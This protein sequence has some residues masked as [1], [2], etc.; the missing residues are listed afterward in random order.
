[1]DM[2]ADAFYTGSGFPRIQVINQNAPFY[3]D[4]KSRRTIANYAS[5]HRIG[6]SINGMTADFTFTEACDSTDSDRNC[7]GM[8]DQARS[9]N[10]VVT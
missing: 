3:H 2:Y 8:Y 7:T 10:N 5:S 1:M 4:V 9:F 6:L